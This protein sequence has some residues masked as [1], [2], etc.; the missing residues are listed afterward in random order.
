[1]QSVLLQRVQRAFLFEMWGTRELYSAW[2]ISW[3]TFHLSQLEEWRGYNPTIRKGEHLFGV[4]QGLPV[5]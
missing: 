3:A 4:P 1:M 2:T 5:R